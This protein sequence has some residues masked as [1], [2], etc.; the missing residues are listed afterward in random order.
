MNLVKHISIINVASQNL[1]RHKLKTLS[2]VAPLFLVMALYGAMSFTSQGL[3]KDAQGALDFT[4][5][6]L[7]QQLTGGR[8]S[9]ISSAYQKKIE[10]IKGVK[11][12]V[13]RVWGYIP[14]SLYLKDRKDVI[15]TFMGIDVTRMPVSPKI[16][17]SLEEGRFLRDKDQRKIVVGR[18]F[19]KPFMVN[20]GDRVRFKNLW[21][22]EREYE[23]AGIFT[24]A[25][26]I[27]T[28]GL[29]LA[30]MDDARSFFG[31]E[32][33]EA[34]DLCVY[35]DYPDSAPA[36]AGKI[37]SDMPGLRTLTK[38]SISEI[39]KQV[40]GRKSGIFQILWMILLLTSILIAL[41]QAFN[42]TTD[43]KREVGILKALGWSVLDVIEM[44]SL[45]SLTMGLLATFGGLAAAVW[46]L[47]AGAPGIKDYFLGWSQVYPDFPVP[48]CVDFNTVLLMLTIGVFPILAATII[49]CWIIGVI[50]PDK[51]VRI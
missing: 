33:D 31:Y 11:S 46:Y 51:A 29:I 47:L 34:S 4:P 36:L 1:W 17:L 43:M 37:S 7:V 32:S 35:L 8:I 48:L 49:P 22:E 9:K 40:F 44:K 28:A 26:S 21:G 15:Y 38:E 45:E 16:A 50:D 6:I 20:A 24:S 18:G 19:S 10:K 2:V 3:L 27:Y 23:V 25:V 30:P 42:I 39:N 5:D 12:V 13:P 41:A 14:V